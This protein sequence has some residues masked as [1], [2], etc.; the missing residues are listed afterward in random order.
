MGSK[1]TRGIAVVRGVATGALIAAAMVAAGVGSRPPLGGAWAEEAGAETVQGAIARTVCAARECPPCVV[2]IR[3]SGEGGKVET[4]TGILLNDGRVLTA[5]HVLKGASPDRPPQVIFGGRGGR[6]EFDGSKGRAVTWKSAP[7]GDLAAI[8]G[9]AVPPW[10]AGIAPGGGALKPGDPIM[11]VGLEPFGG[12]RVYAGAMAGSDRI[13]PHLH[14][15]LMAQRGDSGGPAFDA[16]GNLVGI[17]SGGG[18]AVRT[19]RSIEGEAGKVTTVEESIGA[20]VTFVVDLGRIDL[21]Q[22]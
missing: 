18:T 7:K 1:G 2:L 8:R 4:G 6:L 21:N 17:V 22:F 16:R 12:L 11:L 3:V 14:V 5:A 13:G 19:T 20:P 15:N 10:A 9:V